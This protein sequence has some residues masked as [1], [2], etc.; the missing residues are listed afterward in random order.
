MERNRR[1]SW[2]T[3]PGAIVTDLVRRSARLTAFVSRALAVASGGNPRRRSH[4]A[5]AVLDAFDSAG[6][7]AVAATE[8]VLAS[9]SASPSLVMPARTSV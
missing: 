6:L 5:F 4:Y 3:S 8:Q 9:R 2:T 1:G 7:L